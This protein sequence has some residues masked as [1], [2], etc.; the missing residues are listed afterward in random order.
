MVKESGLGR[1]G[2]IVMRLCY[3]LPK[4]KKFE[5]LFKLKELGTV[6]VGTLRSNRLPNCKLKRDK[7]L[8]Y[9]VRNS[10]DVRCEIGINIVAVK[11]FY[12]KLI[13]SHSFL[14]R[15]SSCWCGTRLECYEH[16]NKEIEKYEPLI[17]FRSNT[18]H[19]FL[20]IDK[21]IILKRGRPSS[22]TSSS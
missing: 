14:Q 6:S 1:S 11:W 15:S 22:S 10:F 13:P 9:E 8:K 5:L 7:T 19:D 2:D 4:R 12:N 18:A 21:E 17:A 16:M 3:N 20:K